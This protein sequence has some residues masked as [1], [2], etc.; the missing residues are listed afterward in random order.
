[1]A[2]NDHAYA[3][4]G[5]KLLQIGSLTDKTV[6]LAQCVVASTGN[7][8]Y[9]LYAGQEGVASARYIHC[10]EG[11]GGINEAMGDAAGIMVVAGDLSGVVD[12]PGPG[13]RGEWKVDGSEC[14]GLKQ[15]AVGA[16]AVRP[17]SNDIAGGVNP[18]CR[19][20]GSPGE[21]DS[22]EDTATAD[23]SM[24]DVGWVDIVAHDLSGIVGADR[25]WSY[26]YIDN[27]AEAHVA[28]LVHGRPGGEYPLGGENA[29][30]LRIFDVVR[31]VRGTPLPR[32]LPFG[33]AGAAGG[34]E[35]LRAWMFG[36]TPL[37]TRGVVEIFRH[38]WPLDS[39]RSIDELSYQV[40]PVVEGLRATLAALR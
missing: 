22:C 35:E 5:R 33:L 16:G 17:A 34:L 13:A 27:V 18:G 21:V 28:A 32:R 39:R 20:A 4:H 29:P 6:N 38:D 14:A 30:Q 2:R 12:A 11:S 25:V 3:E 8:S 7:Q 9:I 36:T 1:M 37:I 10:A 23:E 26:A 19:C 31:D 15:K 40:T 24:L